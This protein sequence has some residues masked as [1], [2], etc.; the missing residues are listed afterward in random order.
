MREAVSGVGVP[1]MVVTIMLWRLSRL[2]KIWPRVPASCA[3][4]ALPGVAKPSM[5][6]SLPVAP[7]RASA[8]PVPS[9]PSTSSASSPSGGV[10]VEKE[11]VR[12]GRDV[13]SGRT[14]RASRGSEM[15][16]SIS[17]RSIAR[18]KRLRHPSM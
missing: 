10:V 5:R 15:Y 8:S 1:Q 9:P 7:A 2:T 14:I 17:R 4:H 11:W 16:A 12:A 18:P 6:A 3:V 13:P